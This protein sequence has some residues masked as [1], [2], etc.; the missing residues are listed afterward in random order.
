MILETKAKLWKHYHDEH[1]DLLYGP[2]GE[3]KSAWNK[4]LTKDDNEILKKASET[5][6]SR[7]DSGELIGSWTGCH[8]SNETKRKISEKRIQWLKEHPDEH[9]WRKSTKF[10]S[11]PCELLKKYLKDAEINFIEEYTGFEDHNYAI[12]IAFPIDKIGIEVNGNQHYKKDGS[13]TE[14]YKNREDYLKSQGWKILQLHY[15]FVYDEDKVHH[16]IN[17]IKNDIQNIDVDYSVFINQKSN[18][19]CRRCERDMSYDLQDGLCKTCI[20]KRQIEEMCNSIIN[21][22]I[23]F[24]KFG[25]VGKVSRLLGIN[26]NKGGVWV[27]KHMPDFFQEK[28]FKR[29]H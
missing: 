5:L 9:P 29:K 4:G 28:C 7:Y 13:L 17:D 2:H 12:D 15:S 3:G 6:K 23:D 14:Y 24:S 8:H 16:L 21:S 1:K 18:R 19:K 25:W 11:T 10:K 26:E 27:K 20:K 22:N